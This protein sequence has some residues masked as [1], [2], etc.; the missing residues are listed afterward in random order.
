MR[1]FHAYM[2]HF[3][4]TTKLPNIGTVFGVTV[5]DEPTFSDVI[6]QVIV[7][8]RWKVGGDPQR[9]KN[10]TVDSNSPSWVINAAF[11]LSPSLM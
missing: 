2:H 8:K 4:C 10:I 1:D 6:C 7:H 5:D 9:L 3:I 11:H